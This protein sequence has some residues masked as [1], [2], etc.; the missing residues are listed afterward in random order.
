RSIAFIDNSASGLGGAMLF[1][2]PDLLQVSGA[3]FR[4]NEAV[5]GGAVYLTAVEDK[6]TAFSACDFE[7]NLADDGGAFYL[8]TG[9]GVDVFT[10]SVFK[11]NFASKSASY[12][13]KSE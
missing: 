7:G 8:Y 11:N 6:Q 3:T 4:S 9:P 12:S 2:S 5:L 10:E 13:R 1:Q